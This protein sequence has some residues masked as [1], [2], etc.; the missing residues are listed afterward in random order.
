MNA[1]ERIAPA[2]WLALADVVALWLQRARDRHALAQLTA[3]ERKDMGLPRAAVE[4]EMRKPFWR[5]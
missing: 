4:L 2:F 1:P 5:A 3:R